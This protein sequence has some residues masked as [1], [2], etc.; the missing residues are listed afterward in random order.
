[1]KNI[2]N[3]ISISLFTQKFKTKEQ[4]KFFFQFNI[5]ANY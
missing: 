2:Y 5:K 4:A 1:M 3:F